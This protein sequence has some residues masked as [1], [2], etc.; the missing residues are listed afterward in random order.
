MVWSG[1]EKEIAQWCR[2]NKIF[3]EISENEIEE[4]W[5]RETQTKISPSDS[6]ESTSGKL[7][8]GCVTSSTRMRTSSTSQRLESIDA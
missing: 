2:K 1:N 4:I 3:D 5:K 6:M 8:S 7:P